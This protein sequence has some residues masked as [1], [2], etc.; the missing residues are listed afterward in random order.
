MVKISIP[1]INP[2]PVIN[3]DPVNTWVFDKSL[4]NLFE[5]LE[6]TTLDVTVCTT[7]VCAVN[8]PV[9]VNEPDKNTD[10]VI[11]WFPLKLFDPVVAK[12]PVLLFKL[13]V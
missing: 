5:P 3:T 2:E 13:W 8:V 7:S 10:P 11:F 6:K 12:D 9:D 1:F 4:P